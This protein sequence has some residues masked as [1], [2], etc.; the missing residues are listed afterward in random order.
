MN[1]DSHPRTHTAA[2]YRALSQFI[3]GAALLGVAAAFKSFVIAPN[4]YRQFSNQLSFTYVLVYLSKCLIKNLCHAWDRV[5]DR[6]CDGWN[7]RSIVLC[8]IALACKCM[9]HSAV[10]TV[11][12]KSIDKFLGIC[13]A[14]PNF[15]V[16]FLRI[17]HL[18]IK[19][20]FRPIYLIASVL[21][22]PWSVA[23]FHVQCTAFSHLYS[24]V[25]TNIFVVMWQGKQLNIIGTMLILVQFIYW[26]LM[27]CRRSLI[28]CY[29]VQIYRK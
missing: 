21:C 2:Y 8:M 22:T 14:K 16:I 24:Y 23:M 6:M 15:L 10:I 25:C 18:S 12:H 28:V 26:K 13:N 27:K 9:C 5:I 7:D 29:G 11:L 4:E 20:I 3:S 17:T 19:S 1:T